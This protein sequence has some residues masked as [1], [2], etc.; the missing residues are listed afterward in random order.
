MLPLISCIY[1][2]PDENLN[3]P[4]PTLLRALDAL[5]YPIHPQLFPRAKGIRQ[6]TR[7]PSSTA[8]KLPL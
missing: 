6:I 8:A 1:C 3:P 7:V 5:A 2:I 4:A